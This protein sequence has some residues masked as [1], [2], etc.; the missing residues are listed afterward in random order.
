LLAK[1]TATLDVLSGGRLDLGVGV[2][3][4]Q[5]E[6]DAVG[7]DFGARGRLLDEALRTCRALWTGEPVPMPEPTWCRP[8]PAQVGGV[9]IWISG[10]MHAR[11]LRR[12]VEL[13]DGWIPWVAGPAEVAD[14]VVQARR[15]LGEAGR[16]P[17]G[18]Q[19][20]S[21]LRVQVDADDRPDLAATMDAVPSL[22]SDG[23][24]DLQLAIPPVVR[25]VV[26]ADLPTVVG[27]F[28]ARVAEVVGP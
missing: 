17:S 7:L 1:T 19:V 9:P 8:V 26:L 27:T 4:Q 10:R 24:T 20:R 23:V 14:G 22:L 18:L 15:A 21:H 16:D 13:G 5:A 3:W 28:R 11:T 12:I 6:Y 25:A 2:G